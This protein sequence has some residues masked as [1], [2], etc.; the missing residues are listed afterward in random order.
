M[1]RLASFFNPITILVLM[2][3]SVVVF[4]DYFAPSL[5]ILIAPL[6]IVAML[7]TI[8]LN[9]FLVSFIRDSHKA[10]LH[11][12]LTHRLW[13]F[14]GVI[15]ILVG[16]LELAYFGFP[17]LGDLLYVEFGF[18]ILHHLAVSTWLLIFIEFSNKNFNRLK[19]LYAILF[20]IL[21]FNRDI[22][23]VTVLCIIFKALILNKLRWVHI[24]FA[25]A[26]FLYV[27]TLIGSIRSG[28]IEELINIPVN[29]NINNINPAFLWL[30]VYST[31]PSFNLHYNL[32][33]ERSRELYDPLLTVFPEYYK[34]I[35]A[36]SYPGLYMYLFFGAFIIILPRLI[37]FPGWI[38]FSLF[39]YYQFIMGCVFSNKLLN[40]HTLF[41]F[42]ILIS[43]YIC[44]Q[45]FKRVNRI[46]FKEISSY[47]N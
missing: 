10:R 12:C 16:I 13:R 19:N 36:F 21:I 44:R 45:A 43:V 11:V 27:F 17:I 24:L 2:N 30:F 32:L 37:R 39:F 22:F 7:T 42:I 31:A 38:C 34:F 40:T 14:I 18:P 3:L 35:E 4:Y 1:T 47:K 23:L 33:F 9:R 8:I 5:I 28:A 20:P 41:V 46:K 15:I 6:A 29:I 26:L 25:F